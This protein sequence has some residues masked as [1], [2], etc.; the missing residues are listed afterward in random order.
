MI[1]SLYRKESE[2]IKKVDYALTYW[3]D[4]DYSILKHIFIRNK[5]NRGKT[6]YAD[7]IMMA[8]TETSKK[9]LNVLKDRKDNHV[10]AWSL[11]IRAYHTN[12]VTLWG[13]SPVDMMECINRIRKQFNCEEVY[14]YF[15]NLGYD[16]VFLRKFLFKAF[17]KPVNQLNVKPYYPLYIKFGNGLILKDS[18]MLSQRKLERWAVDLDVCHKKAVGKWDYNQIRTQ[19]DILTPDEL[20]Y[21]ECDVLAGVEC[22]DETCKVLRKTI[23]SIPYTATG[24]VRGECR[25]EGRKFRAHDWFKKIQ[26]DDYELQLTLELLFNGGYTH[27]DRNTIDWVFPAKCYDE[28]SAYPFVLLTEKYIKEKPWKFKKKID[29]D[30]VL[31]NAEDWAFIFKAKVKNVRLKNKRFPMPVLSR[32]KSRVCYNPVID[33]GRVLKCDYVEIYMNE[34][35]LGVFESQYTYDSIEFDDVYVA[36]KDYLPRWFTDYVFERFKLKTQMKGTGVTYTIEKAKLN[37]LYGMTA[38]KSVKPDIKENYDTGEYDEVESY[39]PVS[40][41]AEFLNNRNSFLPYTIAPWVTSYARR[42]LFRVG[43]CV[44]DDGIWLYSDTDSVY[45]T[46]FDEDKIAAYNA[47]CIDKLKARGYDGVEFKGKTYYCG[48]LEVDGIYSQ[49]KALHSKCYCKREWIADG[50]NFVMSGDLKITVAGVPKRGV[51]SLKNNIND[52]KVGFAFDGETSG[53][54]THSHIF[55]DDIYTDEDGNITGDSID[56]SPCTYIIG[57]A[58]IPKFDEEE[59]I[60][61]QVYD[62]ENDHI[63]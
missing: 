30:Y 59:D 7:V 4:F 40:K 49:F 63:L 55:V 26:P 58:N 22:I 13:Q 44:A 45:A 2:N 48:I 24:I 61:V 53:K 34:I 32:A 41:Y 8:D 6:T 3:T 42:N 12:I 56:L 23:A 47:A 14:L 62:E 29:V 21:I 9:P 39:D 38:Q 15:H 60:E 51:K 5:S 43:D 17:G 50:D 19:H 37:A 54:L 52:F 25:N 46:K 31:K 27:A 36:A 18:L 57:D 28:T 11:A 10:C 33:N 20:L 35:D 1:K 16:Y